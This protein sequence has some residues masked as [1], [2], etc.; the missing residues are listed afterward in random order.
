MNLKDIAIKVLQEQGFDGL[1]SLHGCGCKLD[2]LMP[3]GEPL[4][5]CTA[6]HVIPCDPET[7]QADGKCDWHI[8]KRQA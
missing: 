5:E 7:C 8:G 6:G 1:Y 3:C 2:D 4:P